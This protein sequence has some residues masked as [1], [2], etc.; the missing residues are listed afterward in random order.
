LPFLAILFQ[1]EV[2]ELCGMG[3]RMGIREQDR[4]MPN[5]LELAD[6]FLHPILGRFIIDFWESLPLCWVSSFQVGAQLGGLR[7]RLV[8]APEE[9]G[10][11]VP[12][13]F[14][15]GCMLNGVV[16]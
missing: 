8:F 2:K 10:G 4:W 16:F 3:C 14:L 6:H 12:P 11:A 13:A 5:G 9:I 15:T 1:S 7:R